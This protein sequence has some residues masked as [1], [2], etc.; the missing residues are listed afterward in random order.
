MVNI[1]NKMTN[2]INR[3][4]K[5]WVVAVDMGYGHQRTVYP[6][7]DFA[8]EG[9]VI[10]ANNYEGISNIDRN[11]WKLAKDFYESVS[12]FKKFPL[13]GNAVFGILE[14]LKKILNFYPKR[15][16]SKSNLTLKVIFAFIKR[17]WGKNL[18]KANITFRVRFD[19]DKS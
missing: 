9:K 5:A 1:N 6:L 17:G 10:S 15:D 12:D 18:I 13:L 4:Q 3:P 19:F 11:V 14:K 2:E 7:K 8:F 16:L